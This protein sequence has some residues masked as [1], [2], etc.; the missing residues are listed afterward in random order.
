MSKTTT[1]I[2]GIA[3]VA[4]LAFAITATYITYFK[5]KKL[6]VI[7]DALNQILQKGGSVSSKFLL[8]FNS[9]SWSSYQSLLKTLN[10]KIVDLMDF[11]VFSNQDFISTLTNEMPELAN[12]PLFTQAIS[13]GKLD[14]FL[15]TLDSNTQYQLFE[16]YNKYCNALPV[17]EQTAKMQEFSKAFEGLEKLNESGIKNNDLIFS[18]CSS[19]LLMI[20]GVML[21]SFLVS[22]IQ[23]CLGC[24]ACSKG[25]SEISFTPVGVVMNLCCFSKGES[26]QNKGE[27]RQF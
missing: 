12:N 23:K 9:L 1:I 15:K 22:I 14:E 5:D 10:N 8:T 2:S 19:I 25:N 20:A 16:I 17:A 18:A 27:G 6:Q 4:I 26:Q 11:T 3:F 7:Y 24:C 13:D 21:A